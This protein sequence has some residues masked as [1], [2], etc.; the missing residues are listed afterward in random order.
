MDINFFKGW[1]FEPIPF[2]KDATTIVDFNEFNEFI[3]TTDF[4]EYFQWKK[5]VNIRDALYTK[6][7]LIFFYTYCVFFESCYKEES[8][9]MFFKNKEWI[10]KTLEK[11]TMKDLS[12][13]FKENTENSISQKWDKIIEEFI[14]EENHLEKVMILALIKKEFKT[15]FCY[16]FG[17]WL[18][19][20][21]VEC[22][23]KQKETEQEIVYIEFEPKSGSEE[24]I[25]E[26]DY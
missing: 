12:P 15:E 10:K 3:S 20:A 8:E 9:Q 23:F 4:E 5:Q 21:I 22:D 7:V 26:E 6:S 17:E 25:D 14:L 24:D 2:F 16:F 19:N 13:I 18:R 1:N 11:E